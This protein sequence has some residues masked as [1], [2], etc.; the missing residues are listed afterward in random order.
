M[1][2]IDFASFFFL[3]FSFSVLW[4]IAAQQHSHLTTLNVVIKV[5]T[6]GALCLDCTVLIR[7]DNESKSP[8]QLESGE[9]DTYGHWP[10][11]C[12]GEI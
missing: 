7:G 11:Y 12:G 9:L 1:I 10:W 8:S 6:D 2:F 5:R 3:R 4:I